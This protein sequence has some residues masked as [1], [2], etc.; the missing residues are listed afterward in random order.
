MSDSENKRLPATEEQYVAPLW[1]VSKFEVNAQ[2]S[3]ILPICNLPGNGDSAL[4]HLLL[5]FALLVWLLSIG[6]MDVSLVACIVGILLHCEIKGIWWQVSLVGVFVGSVNCES[7]S[8][9]L[10]ADG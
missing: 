8:S 4:E 3:S 2:L 5:S 7:L 1:C 10:T 9:L 6:K